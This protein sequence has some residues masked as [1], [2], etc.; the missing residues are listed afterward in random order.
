MGVDRNTGGSS[1]DAKNCLNKE[2]SSAL[3]ISGGLRQIAVHRT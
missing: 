2:K 1:A 3:T